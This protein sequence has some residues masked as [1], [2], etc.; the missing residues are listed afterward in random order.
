MSRQ[1]KPVETDVGR[2]LKSLAD[3][4]S[5]RGD[6]YRD[7]Y[8]RVGA[9]LAALFSSGVTLSSPEDFCRFALLVHLHGKLGRYAVMFD[10]GGH[11]DSLDDMAVYSQIL[12][13]VDGEAR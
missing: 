13:K 8:V 3:L 6:L 11:D 9:S 10:R 12:R 1:L 5:E 4:H 2:A 7:D